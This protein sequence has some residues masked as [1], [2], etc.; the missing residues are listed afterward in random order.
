MDRSVPLDEVLNHD[1]TLNTTAM[2]KVSK[3]YRKRVADDS[4][5]TGAV[6]H[7]AKSLTPAPIP[8]SVETVQPVTCRGDEDEWDQS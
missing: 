4:K 3:V 2:K 8:V 5:L 6:I 7:L 1:Q